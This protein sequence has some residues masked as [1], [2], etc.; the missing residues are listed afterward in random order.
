MPASSRITAPSSN[1]AWW[2]RPCTWSTS[3]LRCPIS[4]ASPESTK[5][6]LERWFDNQSSKAG[7]E[8]NLGGHS[9]SRRGRKPGRSL[10]GL[11]YLILQRTGR[12]AAHRCLA[13]RLLAL[14]R[15][16]CLGPGRCSAFCGSGMWRALPD[17]RARDGRGRPSGS[18]SSR[19]AL[20]WRAWVAPAVLLLA[21][22]PDLRA[23]GQVLAT[24]RGQQL[25]RPAVGLYRVLPREP[26]LPGG[27]AP[28]PQTPICR[29]SST[30]WSSGSITG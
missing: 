16:V 11:F 20:T 27:V 14:I 23:V 9:W 24:G 10:A 13:G 12:P 7:G 1:L 15:G 18:S 30:W 22:A 5:L 17:T 4:K 19:P 8:L 3:A 29:C 21:I 26:A 2:G 6:F 28:K 25:V